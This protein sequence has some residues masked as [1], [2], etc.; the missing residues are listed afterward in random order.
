MKMKLFIMCVRG[1]ESLPA[2]TY[3]NC[4]LERRLM[5]KFSSLLS[6]KQQ[7]RNNRLVFHEY[8]ESIPENVIAPSETESYDVIAPMAEDEGSSIYNVTLWGVWVGCLEERYRI[9]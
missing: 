6:I 8:Q 2:I 7:Q 3:L 9:L 1:Q 5:K 4:Q